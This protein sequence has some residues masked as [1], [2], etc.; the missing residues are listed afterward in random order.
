MF[1]NKRIS[2]SRVDPFTYENIDHYTNQDMNLSGEFVGGNILKPMRQTLVIQE[3]NSL[4]FNMTI[5]PEGMEVY[6]NKGILYN[7]L[8]M[9]NKGLIGSGLLK[10]LTSTTNSDEF[11][12]FPDSM[13]THASTFNI[14]K[15]SAGI[16]P[17]LKSQDVAIKW[18]TQ[19]D[20]W[21]ATPCYRQD[22]Q[23]VRERYN[24]GWRIKSVLL[25]N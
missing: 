15:D 17:V 11:K 25:Q 12:F 6:G 19:K 10:H 7:A 20:E 21:M 24:S 9:S 16:F 23:Y 22:I 3:N 8:S 14:E 18:L 4:G 5:P 1:I 13:I 2:I